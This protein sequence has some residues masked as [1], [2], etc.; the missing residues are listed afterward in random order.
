MLHTPTRLYRTPLF[1]SVQGLG[2][3][4]GPKQAHTLSTASTAVSNGST[5]AP[6]GSGGV[7][8]APGL[9]PTLLKRHSSTPSLACMAEGRAEAASYTSPGG[10]A[11]AGACSA[12]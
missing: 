7:A 12:R 8:P 1:C 6:A 9:P 2:Y 10:Q 11:A 3:R 5:G 4:H